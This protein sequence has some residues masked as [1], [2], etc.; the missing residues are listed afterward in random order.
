MKPAI[1]LRL[2]FARSISDKHSPDEASRGLDRRRAEGNDVLRRLAF[3]K[4][5]VHDERR[6]LGIGLGRERVAL[7]GE[8]LP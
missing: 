4:F 2:A 6:D 7:G 5:V 3:A 8:F 1:G